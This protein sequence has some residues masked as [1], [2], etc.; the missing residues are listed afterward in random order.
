MQINTVFRWFCSLN[1]HEAERQ[2]II[3]ASIDWIGVPFSRFISH[4]ASSE[5]D[6][7]TNIGRSPD[8]PLVVLL[9]AHK[10]E[11]LIIVGERG[12]Q[13]TNRLEIVELI[14]FSYMYIESACP[15]T[16]V[17]STTI[18]G[19]SG[20]GQQLGGHLKSF[21]YSSIYLLVDRFKQSERVRLVLVFWPVATY[22]ILTSTTLWCEI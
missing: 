17:T 2:K 7:Q 1:L 5:Y 3:L 13:K 8:C 15:H 18:D 19:Q 12:I 14:L 4:H 11:G 16:G 6:P 10:E 9:E 20:R 22:L 21:T